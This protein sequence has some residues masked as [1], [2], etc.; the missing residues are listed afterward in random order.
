MTDIFISYARSTA[1][2]A[3]RAAEALRAQGYQVWRDD[4]LPAHRAYSD[5]IEERLRAAK[6]V[7]VLWS[8]DAVKSQWVRAEADL[9]REAGTLVQLNLDGSIL[10]LP[11]NQIQCADMSGWSGDASAPGWRKVVDSIG[12]LM[13]VAQSQSIIRALPLPTKPSIAVMPLV[14]LS[15]DP[16]QE[17]FADGMVVEIVEALSRSRSIF[18]IASGSSLTFKNKGATAQVAAHQLGVRYILEGSVRRAGI[19]VRIGVQLIDA[20]D[21]TLIWTHR[22]EDTLDDIF[23]LQDRVA[24]AVAGRIEPTVLEAEIRRVAIRPTDNMGSYDLYLRAMQKFR[25]L[26]RSNVLEA[27][28]LLN[29]AI[30]LDPDFGPALSLA[31]SCHRTVFTYGWSDDADEDRRLT[32]DLTKRALKVANE[33]ADV[34]ARAANMLGAL[35]DDLAASETMA[36]RAIALNPG[37]SQ[38]WLFSGFIRLRSGKP[39]LAAEHIEMAMRLDPMN[40]SRS[41][42]VGALGQARFQQGRFEDAAPLLREAAHESD[43]PLRQALLA[44]CLGQLGMVE[45]ART[46]M[47]RYRALTTSSPA[48]IGKVFIVNPSHLGMFLE[49]I[50]LADGGLSGDLSG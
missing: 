3:Q 44:A 40:P 50:A 14:N 2:E 25:T 13:G 37:S 9:A 1:H 39:D 21:G 30:D 27:L 45:E 43:T 49:G 5:V 16:D 22:F 47:A 4:E 12:L 42:M 8:A 26:E 7:V 20:A 15:G 29:R 6:A 32:F 41:I 38:V 11:F 23:E 28:N 36:D 17:Y 33:D 24:L 46:A 34:L 35:G 10:P 31:A 19:R 48:D 18:V